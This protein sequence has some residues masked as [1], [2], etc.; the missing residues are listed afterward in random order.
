MIF[1]GPDPAVDCRFR[2][3]CPVALPCR[4]GDLA[5]RQSCRRKRPGGQKCLPLQTERQRHLLPAGM[6]AG[7]IAVAAT[8]AK[9]MMVTATAIRAI[10]MTTALVTGMAHATSTTTVFGAAI[11]AGTAIAHGVVTVE[12]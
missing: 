4:A 3:C 11:A 2:P 5:R 8:G 12:P 7:G 9:T 10:A 1:I 6:M